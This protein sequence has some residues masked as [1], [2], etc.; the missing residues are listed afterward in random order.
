LKVII[1]KWQKL[2]S[3]FWFGCPVGDR[4]TFV[5]NSVFLYKRTKSAASYFLKQCCL[6]ICFFLA[7]LILELMKIYFKIRAL[8]M[9]KQIVPTLSAQLKTKYFFKE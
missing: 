3:L 7:E 6:D 2:S 5:C 4:S 1:K 8:N 9:E